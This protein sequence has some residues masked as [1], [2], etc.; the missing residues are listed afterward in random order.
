MARPLC[1]LPV[2]I[3]KVRFAAQL[4]RLAYLFIYLFIFRLSESASATHAHVSAARSRRDDAAAFQYARHGHDAASHDAARH[5]LSA[6]ARTPANV[7]A[8]RKGSSRRKAR[9]IEYYIEIK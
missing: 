1:L 4:L 2:K 9:R 5:A 8:A 7:H 3:H 6:H